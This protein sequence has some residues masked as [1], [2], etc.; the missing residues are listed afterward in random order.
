[1]TLE[2]YHFQVPKRTYKQQKEQATG[3]RKRA[4]EMANTAR[5]MTRGAQQTGTKLRKRRA[6]RAG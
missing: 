4:K 6:N 3:Q 2:V 1:M 5:Q